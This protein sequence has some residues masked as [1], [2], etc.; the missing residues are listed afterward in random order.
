MANSYAWEV[1]NDVFDESG[2]VVAGPI[3]VFGLFQ[4]KKQWIYC[5]PS[6]G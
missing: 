5:E 2:A 4:S 3:V 1:D 6:I